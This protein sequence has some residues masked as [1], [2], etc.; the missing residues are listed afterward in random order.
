MVFTVVR[1]NCRFPAE[2]GSYFMSTCNR[3]THEGL[4]L[5]VRSFACWFCKN[6]VQFFW[7][8]EYPCKTRLPGSMEDPLLKHLVA[9]H[10]EVHDL[11]CE[12]NLGGKN[13]TCEPHHAK[14]LTISLPDLFKGNW[15]VCIWRGLSTARSQ[16][17]QIVRALWQT[18]THL[19]WI[20]LGD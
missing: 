19:I 17:W 20:D 16:M 15:L 13:N 1:K 8:F 11:S 6:S 18:D 14:V 10:H 5:H 3:G 4:L 9:L 2:L 12:S 7:K